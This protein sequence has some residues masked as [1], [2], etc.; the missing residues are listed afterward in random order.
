MLLVQGLAFVLDLFQV[1]ELSEQTLK[2]PWF[3][4][5]PPQLPELNAA[6]PH[7]RE[8]LDLQYLQKQI[9][10]W[11]GLQNQFFQGNAQ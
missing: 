11:L 3:V 10:Q 9:L 7:C 8:K 2:L 1:E 6:R 5:A 4:D